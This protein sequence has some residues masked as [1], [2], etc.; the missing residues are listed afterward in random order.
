MKI[1][2]QASIVAQLDRAT[3]ETTIDWSPGIGIIDRR[4]LEI[5]LSIYI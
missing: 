2:S 1:L 5:D 3:D 4:E